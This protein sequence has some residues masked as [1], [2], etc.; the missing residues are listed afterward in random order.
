MGYA[1]AHDPYEA[2]DLPLGVQT[3]FSRV[4]RLA[5]LKTPDRIRAAIAN[6]T[7][8]APSLAEVGA[9]LRK[10]E[11]RPEYNVGEPQDC[12]GVDFAPRSA[13]HRVC[14]QRVMSA[15]ARAEAEA[16][17][18]A[19][20]IAPTPLEVEA[21]KRAAE[22]VP[23]KRPPANPFYKAP[24]GKKLIAEVCD[25]LDLEVEAVLGAGRNRWLVDCRALVAVLLRE[26]DPIRYSFPQIGQML[27]G[28]DHSTIVNL[29]QNFDIYCKR[30]PH[31]WEVYTALG[32]KHAA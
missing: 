3:A 7:G 12:D 17:A 8:S 32:G 11:T 10:L 20:Y 25:E 6:E 16:L 23:D 30:S 28:R 4:Q 22:A 5:Y 1:T 26:K 9:I 13:D 2:R 18:R 27:G 31:L 24:F 15:D 19:R 29:V 14:I 21:V